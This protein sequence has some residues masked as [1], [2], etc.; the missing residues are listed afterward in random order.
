MALNN[1]GNIYKAQKMYPEAL[2]YFRLGLEKV[3]DSDEK[4]FLGM[5][6]TNIG[7][8]QLELQDYSEAEKQFASS[9]NWGKVRI[10]YHFAE[11][12]FWSRKNE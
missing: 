8:I 1:V 5:L 3:K 10:F 2:R 12:Q 9:S 4:Q 11:G 6:L 7:D